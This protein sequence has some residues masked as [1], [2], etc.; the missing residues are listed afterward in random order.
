MLRVSDLSIAIGSPADGVDI[1][2]SVS[3]AIRKG[4]ILGL[5]GESGCG[6]SLTSLAIMGLMAESGPWVRTGKVELEG[7]EVTHLPP[8]RR[9]VAGHG[10]IAM[11]FQEPRSSLNPVLK[12]GEQIEEA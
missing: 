6:K 7:Y 3:F 5:V 2:S 11:I 9:V 8:Y 12:I 4:E 1:V 10:G